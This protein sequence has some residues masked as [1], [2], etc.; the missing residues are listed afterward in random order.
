LRAKLRPVAL[1]AQERI[2]SVLAHEEQVLFLDLLTRIVEG[3]Q[4]YARPGNGRRKPRRQGES[5]DLA[6]PEA[7]T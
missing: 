6:I 3:N 2:M 4:A 5:R 7:S 1:R